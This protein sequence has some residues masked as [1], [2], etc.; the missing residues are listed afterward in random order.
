MQT[1]LKNKDTKSV[2]RVGE[3][4]GIHECR[5][6]YP[7]LISI[8]LLLDSLERNYLKPMVTKLTDSTK[9]IQQ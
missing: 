7:C 8:N 1:E 4:R 2:L 9:Q 3:T 6:Q 5:N